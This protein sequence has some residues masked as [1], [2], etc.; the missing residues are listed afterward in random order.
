MYE[1]GTLQSYIGHSVNLNRRVKDHAKGQDK[2]TGVW[3]Q[4]RWEYIWV[5]IYVVPI[6]SNLDGLTL[7][8]FLCVLEQY[9]FYLYNPTINKV[10]VATP[11]VLQT[12]ETLAKLRELNGSETYV[13]HKTSDGLTLVHVFPSQRSVGAMLGVSPKFLNR[14]NRFNNGYR[15]TLYFYNYKDPN[16]PINIIPLES[17]IDIFKAATETGSQQRWKAVIVT[18]MSTTPPTVTKYRSISDARAV[19]GGDK[20]VYV[21]NRTKLYRRRYKIEIK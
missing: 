14:V 17:L 21:P 11:G 3:I 8:E 15:D 6:T 18:D 13:Y 4:E 1:E 2:T 12:P 5:D 20:S 10:V 19:L 9:L 16:L 7:S